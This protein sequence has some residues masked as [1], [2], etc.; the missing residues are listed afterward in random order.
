MKMEHLFK[1]PAPLT[2]RRGLHLD[3]KGLPPTPERFLSLID[4]AAALRF[5]LLLVEWED[6]F[7]WSVDPRFRSETAYSESDVQ[8]FAE[9]ARARNMLLVPLVQCLG[10]METPLSVPGYAPLREL[11]D[12]PAGLNPLAPGAGEL[13][14]GMVDDLLRLLP[15]TRYLHLGGDEAWSFGQHPDTRAFIERHGKGALYLKHVGPVLDRLRDAGV[16][17]ILWHDMMNDWDSA[18]L[19]ALAPRADLM[20][21]GYAGHPD[22]TKRHYQTRH[23]ERFKAH[24]LALWGACAFKGADGQSSDLPDPERRRINTAAWMDVAVR[25]GL[26]GVVATGWSRYSTR[27][28]Q[29]EPLDAA[30]DILVQTGVILHDGQAPEDGLHA[31]V[32]ALETLGEAE[33]FRACRDAMERLDS[34]RRNG[35]QEIQALREIQALGR[36]DPSRVHAVGEHRIQRY[37]ANIMKTGAETEARVLQVFDGLVSRPWMAEYLFSRLTP[38]REAAARLVE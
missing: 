21:W 7:P 20:A 5:N 33:R 31:C 6:T 10:H 4:L 17:P 24:G 28:L 23:L 8:R 9:A 2:P 11:P 13:V 27:R 36:F 34:V 38:L 18:S 19:Q 14:Q 15:D 3:L 1:T 16:R 37:L 29:C 26:S 32:S 35:W 25:L 30:L 22:E 12:D